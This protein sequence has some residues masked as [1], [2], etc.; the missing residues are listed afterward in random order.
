M[1]LRLH[2]YL[3][4]YKRAHTIICSFK[5]RD[6]S[7]SLYFLSHIGYLCISPTEAGKSVP[8]PI[9]FPKHSFDSCF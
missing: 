6:F 4:R 7:R 9:L 2:R 1:D 8:I 5:M 3:F